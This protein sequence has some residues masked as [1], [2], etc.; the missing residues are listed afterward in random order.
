MMWRIDHKRL[1]AQLAVT[2]AALLFW[3]AVSKAKE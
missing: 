3:L 2:A 1:L